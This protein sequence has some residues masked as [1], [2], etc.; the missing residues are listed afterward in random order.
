MLAMLRACPILQTHVVSKMILFRTRWQPWLVSVVLK[1]E[2]FS[3]VYALY[4]GY[5][6][7]SCIYHQTRYIKW[8]QTR[9]IS[10]VSTIDMY[11]MY[12]LF[13]ITSYNIQ[14][15]SGFSIQFHPRYETAPCDP[16]TAAVR[17]VSRRRDRLGSEM[18]LQA[19]V[20]LPVRSPN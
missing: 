16:D 1:L 6:M 20:R 12:L 7:I 15:L 5:S 10:I 9:Y 8:Y 2:V 19:G 4:H 13:M 18:G 14:S 17:S 3:C 11:L